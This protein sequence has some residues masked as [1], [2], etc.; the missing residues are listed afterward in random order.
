MNHEIKHTP[1]RLQCTTRAV[2]AP[3]GGANE[4]TS[5]AKADMFSD[6]EV[7]WVLETFRTLSRKL[8][9]PLP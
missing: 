7:G 1:K 9:S 3:E 4:R 6:V 2:D 8:K 5:L